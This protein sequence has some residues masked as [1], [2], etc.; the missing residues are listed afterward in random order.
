[1]DLTVRPTQQ[2]NPS[3]PNHTILH[4]NKMASTGE[5]LY[6]QSRPVAPLHY[7]KVGGHIDSQTQT[8]FMDGKVLSPD[9][10]LLRQIKQANPGVTIRVTPSYPFYETHKAVPGRTVTQTEDE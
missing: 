8:Y 2:F 1:M 5:G 10:E 9:A 7:N 6:A 4:R 3:L